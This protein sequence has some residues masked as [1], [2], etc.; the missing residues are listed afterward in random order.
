M[1]TVF[2]YQYCFGESMVRALAHPTQLY[3]VGYLLICAVL[4]LEHKAVVKTIMHHF[5]VL[6]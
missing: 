1:R 6:P 4:I 2:T 3:H 5:E